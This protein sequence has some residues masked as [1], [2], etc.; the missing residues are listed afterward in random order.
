MQIKYSSFKTY[1][2][3]CLFLSFC[4]LII[5]SIYFPNSVFIQAQADEFKLDLQN[6]NYYIDEICSYNYININKTSSAPNS[7]IICNCKEGYQSTNLTEY[8]LYFSGHKVQ[9]NYEQKRRFIVFFF[10]IFMLFGLEYLYLGNYHYFIIIFIYIMVI[11]AGNCYFSMT[12][13]DKKESDD[14]NEPITTKEKIR[15]LFKILPI[16]LLIFWVVN[17]ILI[18]TDSITDSNGIPTFDDVKNLFNN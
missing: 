7:P 15:F 10:S 2:K 17:N 12:S 14:E 3:K 11:I 9:C 8:T 16:T 1:A 5:T 4:F 6:V 18:L 13:K